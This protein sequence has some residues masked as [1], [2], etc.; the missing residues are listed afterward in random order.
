LSQV[1]SHYEALLGSRYTWMMGGAERCLAAAR[2]LLH[3]V[4][5]PVSGKAL[6]LGCG[7]GFHARALAERGLGVVA[8]DSSADL[9][10]ELQ[11]VCA[12]FDVEAVTGDL[13]ELARFGKHGPF[14]MILCV[15][16]TLTHLATH[17]DV[18]ELIRASAR[19]LAPKGMLLFEYREQP[20]TMDANDSVFTVRSDRDRIMQCVL[21]FEPDRVW[22]TDVVHE[23]KGTAWQTLKSTYPKLRL[24]TD[25][26]VSCSV[27]AGL[28]AGTNAMRAGR[29]VLTLLRE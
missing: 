19:L 23:W 4:Q 24:A 28:R 14:D 8:V 5:A 6:D 26:L 27:T 3:F 1:E 18:N 12:G 25:D 20:T 11:G 9:L 7:A 16:D 2:E 17:A 29:R 13:T 15:G 22:V 10:D 21:H